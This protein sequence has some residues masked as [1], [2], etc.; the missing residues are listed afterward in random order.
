MVSVEALQLITQGPPKKSLLG[1]GV[2][3]IT[4]NGDELLVGSGD[5]ELM[6]L[7]LN[8]PDLQPRCVQLHR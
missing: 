3:A 6:T 4:V 5:G 2:Q 7:D 8:T 1:M